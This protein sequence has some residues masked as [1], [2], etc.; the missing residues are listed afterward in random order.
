MW[1]KIIELAV[2]IIGYGLDKADIN[3]SAKKSYYEF[4]VALQKS[5]FHRPGLKKSYNKAVEEL[6][7]KINES[8]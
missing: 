7:K 4:V 5:D 3:A 8:K 1:G 6:R 2:R